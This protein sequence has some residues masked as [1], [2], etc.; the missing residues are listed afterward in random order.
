MPEIKEQLNPVAAAFQSL[1]EIIRQWLASDSTTMAVSEIN[2]RLGFKEE[3]RRIIPRLILR[4]AVQDLDP[5]D[6]IND[7]S[8]ELD[9]S[10]E[11]AKTITQDIEAKIFKNAETMVRNEAGVDFSLVYF[12]KPGP[13]KSYEIPAVPA[14]LS[15]QPEPVSQAPEPAPLNIA[16]QAPAA[17]LS[18]QEPAPLMKIPEAKIPTPAEPPRDEPTEPFMIHEENIFKPVMSQSSEEQPT[19]KIETEEF[20][21]QKPAP[22]KPVMVTLE[23]SE[24]NTPPKARI[25]HYSDLR[26]P[27]NNLGLPK[28]PEPKKEDIINLENFAKIKDNTVDLRKNSNTK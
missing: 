9:I 2:N 10:F 28:K 19:I 17:T 21:K 11:N 26:T 20:F 22:S 15:P 8:H 24:S 1:P 3:K 25:V 27:L 18:E 23:T 12:G 5:M 6:F 4:L 13:K 7:L 14:A 16:E